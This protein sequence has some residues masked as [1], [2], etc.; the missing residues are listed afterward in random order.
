M[1]MEGDSSNAKSRRGKIKMALGA[2]RQV[3]LRRENGPTAPEDHPGLINAGDSNT[4][5]QNQTCNE[6]LIKISS[7]NKKSEWAGIPQSGQH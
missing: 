7:L 4:P 5:K 3:S 1:W 6:I 2:I